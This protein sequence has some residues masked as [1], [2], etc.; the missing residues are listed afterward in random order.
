MIESRDI[1]NVKQMDLPVSS[2]E[3]P[4]R[5]PDSAGVVI[6][7]LRAFWYGASNQVHL[8]SVQ[9]ST[10]HFILSAQLFRNILYSQQPLS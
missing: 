2:Q 7:P 5:T 10:V 6:F 3:V 4:L 9:Y 8:Y 1:T